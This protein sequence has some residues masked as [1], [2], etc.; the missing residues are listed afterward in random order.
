MSQQVDD[1]IAD[2]DDIEGRFAH[3]SS[4]RLGGVS[5]EILWQSRQI[6]CRA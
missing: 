3:S 5:V 1:R 4:L 2:A 6:P